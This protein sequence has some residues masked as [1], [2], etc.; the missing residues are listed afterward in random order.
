MSE[1]SFSPFLYVIGWRRLIDVSEASTI[2]TIS[3][4]S[5]WLGEP[6]A[7]LLSMVNKRGNKLCLFHVFVAVGIWNKLKSWEALPWEVEEFH[8]TKPLSSLSSNAL[9]LPGSKI[10]WLFKS[11]RRRAAFLVNRPGKKNRAST[12]A[13]AEDRPIRDNPTT[14]SEKTDYDNI[15]ERNREDLCLSNNEGPTLRPPNDA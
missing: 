7:T 1:L 12:S 11:R 9:S 8:L 15:R 5:C 2:S 6:V 4:A 10:S 13:S 3:L 14:K